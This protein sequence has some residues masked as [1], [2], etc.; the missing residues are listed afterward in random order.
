MSL[1]ARF[2][3]AAAQPAP[4]TGWYD[5]DALSYPDLPQPADLI[6]VT[7]EQWDSHMAKPGGWAVLDG[8]LV[9]RETVPAPLPSGPTPIQ[10]AAAAFASRAMAGITITCR[11]CPA[12][13]AVYSLA[14]PVVEQ[15]GILARDFA[16]GLG[17][18][19]GGGTLPV[20]DLAGDAHS[21]AGPQ[22]VALYRASRD[23][24]YALSVQAAV[25]QGG[26]TPTWPEQ[27]AAI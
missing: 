26:G 21:L 7:P 13:S 25:L 3:H 9:A 19:G 16:A 12:A 22:I 6:E 17:L 14:P 27:V 11:S 15:V 8:A 18:P 24:V 2:D 10:Q 5:T 1:Y 20:A 4:V 23:L